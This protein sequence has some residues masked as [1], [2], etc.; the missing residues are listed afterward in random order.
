M[1]MAVS[2]PLMPAGGLP[3]PFHSHLM[4]LPF[5]GYPTMAAIML[6]TEMTLHQIAEARIAIG[7]LKRLADF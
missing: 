5:P 1:P 6:Y 4:S 2:L 3:F 7:M